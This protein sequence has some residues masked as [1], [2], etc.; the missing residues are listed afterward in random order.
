MISDPKAFST[1]QARAA[2]AGITLSVVPNDGGRIVFIV[3]RWALTREFSHLRDVIAWLD[4]AAE[5]HD[6]DE[7]VAGMVK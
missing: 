6:E 1:L 3:T 5:R 4:S 2:L 7:R